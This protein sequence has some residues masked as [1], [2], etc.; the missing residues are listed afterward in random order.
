M[1][2]NKSLKIRN[3]EL[4][5]SARSFGT[6]IH[7]HLCA[8]AVHTLTHKDVTVAQHL[9]VGLFAASKADK[10]R[11]NSVVRVEA[12]RAWL[13]NFAAVS[14]SPKTPEKVELNQS[15]FKTLMQEMAAKAVKPEERAK[16]DQMKA[17]AK[18]AKANPWNVWQRDNAAS[19]QALDVF[20]LLEGILKRVDEKVEAAK[21]S[22]SAD[23]RAKRLASI[24]APADVLA[25]IKSLLAK[26]SAESTPAVVKQNVTVAR[27]KGKAA[28]T[29][30]RPR[31][32]FAKIDKA[33][34][35]AIVKTLET[36]PAA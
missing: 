17:A 26:A 15:R 27:P 9:L 11:G 13:A 12:I 25:T 6:D 21:E 22:E 4:I 31:A 3:T 35:D 30:K 32:P 18:D 10:T 20:K 14:W 1:S 34:R 19:W 24:N 33:E 8:V 7:N 2:D 36:V 16:S 29:A 5:K 23:E 28:P